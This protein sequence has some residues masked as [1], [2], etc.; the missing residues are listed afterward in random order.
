MLGVL[1]WSS[2]D[3]LSIASPK[4]KGYNE[5]PKKEEYKK[6]QK[7]SYNERPKKA[8]YKNNQKEEKPK[9]R[10]TVGGKEYGYVEDFGYLPV[11][12]LELIDNQLYILRYPDDPNNKPVDIDAL[13]RSNPPPKKSY[14]DVVSRNRF[15]SSKK[16]RNDLSP[17]SDEQY[18]CEGL[19]DREIYREYSFSFLCYP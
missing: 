9:L 17:S 10:V 7:N 8:E 12:R 13:R 19:Q 11:E 18:L 4:A 3:C 16:D 6:S 14:R 15:K 2:F 5:R 1:P